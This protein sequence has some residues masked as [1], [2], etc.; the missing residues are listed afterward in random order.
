VVTNQGMSA[1]RFNGGSGNPTLTLCRGRTYTFSVNAPGH[2]FYIKTV[3]ST[4]T[5]NAYDTGVTGNGA[6]SGNVVFV[7]PQSAPSTLFYACSIHA[8]MEGTIQIVD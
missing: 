5:G 4:G 7:V 8:A 3:A 1:Y 2:P 6:T